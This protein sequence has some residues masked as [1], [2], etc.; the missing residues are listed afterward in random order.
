MD[1]IVL[2]LTNKSTEQIRQHNGLA[3]LNHIQP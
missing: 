1:T 3:M 2:F